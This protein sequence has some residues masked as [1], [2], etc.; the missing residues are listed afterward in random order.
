[1]GVCSARGRPRADLRSDAS[2]PRA[3]AP[4]PSPWPLSSSWLWPWSLSL[5]KRGATSPH[6]RAVLRDEPL[7]AY[8]QKRQLLSRSLGVCGAWA[9]LPASQ[10]EPT[11]SPAPTRRE[12]PSPGTLLARAAASSPRAWLSAPCPAGFVGD[13]KDSY[14]LTRSKSPTI[15]TGCSLLAPPGWH[16]DFF[17]ASPAEPQHQEGRG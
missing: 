16:W 10:V 9:L 2:A 1:M 12:L 15:E 8:L 6:P 17:R 3:D 7:G 11:R 14:H 4:G 13:H 5:K